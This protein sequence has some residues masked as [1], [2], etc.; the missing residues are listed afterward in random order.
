MRTGSS[1]FIDRGWI[2]GNLNDG[3]YTQSVGTYSTSSGD[4]SIEGNVIGVE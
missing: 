2:S 1:F 4:I 3:P